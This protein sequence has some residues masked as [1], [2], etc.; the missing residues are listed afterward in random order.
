M[1]LKPEQRTEL[2]NYKQ[3]LTDSK[4]RFKAIVDNLVEL[5]KRISLE[6]ARVDQTLMQMR[7]QLSPLQ[8]GKFLIWLEKMKNRKEL[9]IFEL[10][11]IK[12]LDKQGSA[13]QHGGEEV[14]EDGLMYS[15]GECDV[16]MG[17]G[18]FGKLKSR[19]F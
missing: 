4:L 10:W 5:K 17:E 13:L 9:N 2:L 18:S 7:T 19:M 11:K 6:C 16:P 14:E 8:I 15:E 1:N 12:K 3:Q